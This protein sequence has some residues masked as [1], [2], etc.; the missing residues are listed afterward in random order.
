MLIPILVLLSHVALLPPAQA[1]APVVPAAIGS[2]FKAAYPNA[3]IKNV[4]KELEAGKTVYEVESIDAGMR[5]DLIYMPDGTVVSFEEEIKEA[6]VPAPVIAAIKARYPKASMTRLERA[7]EKGV[8]T[9]EIQLKGA[10][11][12][13]AVLTPEGQWISPKAKK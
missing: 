5:R 4:S 1:K 6:D 7:L 13:E 11:V 2:A 3:T 9:F 8:T 12:S 10:G